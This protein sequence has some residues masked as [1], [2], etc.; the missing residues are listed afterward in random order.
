MA[1][2]TLLHGSRNLACVQLHYSLDS[3]SQSAVL[4]LL[5]HR[6]SECTF[7]GS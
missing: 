5:C 6:S 1:G 4:G 3:D 2:S 7:I